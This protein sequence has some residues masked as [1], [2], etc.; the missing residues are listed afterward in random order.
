MALS[1]SN[2]ESLD[3]GEEGEEELNLL[4]EV[5][6]VSVNDDVFKD[7]N[8]NDKKE[9]N[10]PSKLNMPSSLLTLTESEKRQLEDV[11]LRIGLREVGL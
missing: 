6:P 9:D 5:E 7:K 10:K 4:E 11:L 3:Q 1:R 8:K 2:S